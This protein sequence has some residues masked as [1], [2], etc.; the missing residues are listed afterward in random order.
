[1]RCRPLGLG[2]V[3]REDDELL[4]RVRELLGNRG[5]VPDLSVDRVGE[6]VL[7]E[8]DQRQPPEPV[9]PE[10]LVGAEL[11]Q[12][13]LQV[14]GPVERRHDTGESARGRPEDPAD[15]RPERAL[16]QALEE[17]RFHQHSVDRAA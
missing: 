12:E 2:H 14:V 17:A 11:E 5:Q 6:R 10:D 8:A 15:A 1:V 9:R 16:A 3:G 7:V 13:L 4:V